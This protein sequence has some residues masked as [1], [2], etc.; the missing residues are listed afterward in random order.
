MLSK[1]NP[2]ANMIGGYCYKE[3]GLYEEASD[4]YKIVQE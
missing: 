4:C 3:L 2:E 1:K